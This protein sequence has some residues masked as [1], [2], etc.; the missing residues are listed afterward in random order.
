LVISTI[1]MHVKSTYEEK[2]LLQEVAAGNAASFT[3]LFYRWQPFLATHIHRIT[4]S[5]PVTEEIVQDV[6]L[7]IW[8]SREALAGIR[9]FK[10]YLLVVSKNMAINA[11]K[12][13]AREFQQLERYRVESI[14]PA[15]DSSAALYSLIDEAIDQLSP[16]QK[17]VYLMHRHQRMTYQEIAAEL[18]IGRESVK[19]H[20][21]LAVHG[22]SKYVHL[23]L[24]LCIIFALG[25]S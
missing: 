17:E 9:S 19:T 14:T 1:G 23:K 4:E 13:M 7:K 21:Q 16:R 24:A 20:L 15:E 8:E 2:D 25:L 11:F 6:F 5:V 10:A 3:E 12:K 22:I 18:G